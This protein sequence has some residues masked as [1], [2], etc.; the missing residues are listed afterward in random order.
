MGNPQNNRKGA[1]GF[2][3][4]PI[5]PKRLGNSKLGLAGVMLLAVF[6]MWLSPAQGGTITENFANNEFDTQLWGLWDTSQEAT[7]EV[8]NQRLEVTVAGP[9][10][11]GIGGYGFTLMGDFEIKADFT[12]I[13]W[14]LNN[15]TQLYISANKISSG[16]FQVG[17]GNSGPTD[18]QEV[19]FT[20]ALENFSYTVLPA[21][22]APPLSG[23]LRL[24][25]TGTK[26][27]GFYLDGTTWHSIGSATDPSLGA[28]VMITLGVGPYGN[29]YSGTPAKA[30]F[31][32]IRITYAARGPGFWQPGNPGPAIMDLLLH[33]NQ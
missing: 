28:R 23:T 25:R 5:W 10:Y 3:P 7:V 8:A 29:E 16:L 9:G 20:L 1:D 21:V 2:H 11:A 33:Q 30:A 6:L 13:N 15:G 4:S 12:L 17:R 26:I 24:V 31:S 27:E 18:G 19:Y 22:P 14:P 32:N